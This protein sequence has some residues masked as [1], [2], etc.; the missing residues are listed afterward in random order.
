MV[1][2][3][4]KTW[5]PWAWL[6][7]CFSV[8][9]L[10]IYR[11]FPQHVDSDMSAL[12]SCGQNL[13]KEGK[14]LSSNWYYAT[15]LSVFSSQLI[16][17]LLFAITDSWRIVRFLGNALQ[18]LLTLICFFYFCSQAGLKRTYPLTASLLLLPFSLQY[19]SKIL[20]ATYYNFDMC[21]T[22]LMAGLYLRC[23]KN[24]RKHSFVF[25]AVILGLLSFLAGLNGLRLIFFFHLPAACLA[26]IVLFAVSIDCQ[27]LSFLPPANARKLFT[28]SIIALFFAGLGYLI[29][30]LILADIF[31]FMHFD[32]TSFQSVNI[33]RFMAIVDDFLLCFGYTTGNSIFSSALLG[34][35]LCAC[36]TLLAIAAVA[37]AL[38]SVPAPASYENS[39]A[40][41]ITLF[42]FIGFLLLGLLLM[43]T[44]TYYNS[45]NHLPLAMFIIPSV[46]GWFLE[47]PSRHRSVYRISLISV[48]C[49]LLLSTLANY[50]HLC[51]TDNTYELRVIS[52]VMTDEGYSD[53][54]SSFWHG[55]VITELS[56]GEIDMR[57]WDV[58]NE[59]NEVMDISSVY[60]CLQT[61]F[62]ET[63]VPEGKPF[64]LFSKFWDQQNL[65]S[66]GRWLREEDIL[67]ETENFMIYGYESYT[68]LL[69]SV[70]QHV[71]AV[72]ADGHWLAENYRR[73]GDPSLLPGAVSAGP[74]IP[75]YPGAYTVTISGEGLSGLELTCLHQG[76][77]LHETD[78]SISEGEIIFR[79]ETTELLHELKFQLENTASDVAQLN[80]LIIEKNF[81]SSAP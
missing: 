71:D 39:E 32:S 34:A 29:N 44:N 69:S 15:E 55:P 43:L 46:A 16:H 28:G 45:G 42:W 36:F 12:L 13:A 18:Y 38:R 21:H 75:L 7:F 77:E 27:R 70:N 11:Y 23:S 78:L 33:D 8:L 74:N 41:L 66:L 67:F 9:C 17:T 35:L 2:K 79:L 52:E 63:T 31:T 76:G 60:P 30:T 25:S 26:L 4:W 65:F 68:D 47:K 80:S 6:F 24:L 56:N 54:Y 62:H 50:I 14:I 57:V 5:L 10:F 81:A 53:G 72:F 1:L 40:K 58:D 61:K 20:I 19:A 48:V 64:I 49:I 51:K 3:K 37:K 59:V 22:F 73:E